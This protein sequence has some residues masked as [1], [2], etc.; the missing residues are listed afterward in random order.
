MIFL[1][2]L[3]ILTNIEDLKQSVK[4]SATA[5]RKAEE[6]EVDVRKRFEELS[7][8]LEEK[9]NDYQVNLSP[10][11]MFCVYYSTVYS[12]LLYSSFCLILAVCTF[13]GASFT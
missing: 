6:G 5:V 4:E 8:S 11:I 13:V 2:I 1:L 3:Q 7:E 9:E 10:V 12:T